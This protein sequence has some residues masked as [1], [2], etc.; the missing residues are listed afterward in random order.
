MNRIALLDP[1]RAT[2]R[3]RALFEIVKGRLGRV[4]NAL[5]VLGHSPA[6]LRAWLGFTRALA[7]GALSPRLRAQIAL[8]VAE[9]NGCTYCLSAHAANGRRAGLSE[10]EI[11]HARRG[12]AS[13]RK[14]DAALKLARRLV[15]LR[16]R[17]ADADLAAVRQAGLSDAEIV[18]IAANVALNMFGNYINL[19]ADPVLDLPEVKPGSYSLASKPA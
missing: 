7:G 9:G 18:E 5:R 14:D 12:T 16:G 8:A 6:A 2:G 10:D 3:T 17:I 1:A 4:P 11:N 15:L 19:L 13:D